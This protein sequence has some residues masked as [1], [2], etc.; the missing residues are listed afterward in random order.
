MTKV[1]KVR[2]GEG[3]GEKPGEQKEREGERDG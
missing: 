3:G 2:E 1:R